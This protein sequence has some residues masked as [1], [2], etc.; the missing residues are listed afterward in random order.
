MLSDSVVIC[1]ATGAL[2]PEVQAECGHR[3]VRSRLH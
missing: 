1:T 2:M 3:S